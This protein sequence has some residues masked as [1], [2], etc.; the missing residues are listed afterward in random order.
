MM[1]YFGFN[2]HPYR[3]RYTLDYVMA[4]FVPLEYLMTSIKLEY[5]AV[6]LG[7]TMISPSLMII[8][9]F[10]ALVKSYDYA[11]DDSRKRKNNEIRQVVHL[12][13]LNHLQSLKEMLERDPDLA[14]ENYKKKSMNY[15]CKK[16]NNQEA[17]SL[18]L[19]ALHDK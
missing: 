1:R 2:Y 10:W 13:Q 15:W 8:A 17:H 11:L 12:I 4:F 18:I 6:A 16:Y 9:V 14:K 3:W 5:F 19:N 7:L